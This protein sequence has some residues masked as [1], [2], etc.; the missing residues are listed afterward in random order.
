MSLKKKKSCYETQHQKDFRK[1]YFK[2]NISLKDTCKILGWLWR[3][4]TILLF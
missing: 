1:C 3:V 4:E 2:S